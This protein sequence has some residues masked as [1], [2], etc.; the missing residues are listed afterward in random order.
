MHVVYKLCNSDCCYFYIAI[1]SDIVVHFYVFLHYMWVL[2]CRILFLLFLLCKRLVP[3][4]NPSTA[5]LDCTWHIGYCRI[6]LLLFLYCT[7]VEPHLPCRILSLLFLHCKRL[8]PCGNP[9][10]VVL[11]CTRHGQSRIHLLLFLH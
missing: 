5:V 6:L 9:S 10:T 1:G 7:S 3:Y 2:N 8:V 4:W 11:H